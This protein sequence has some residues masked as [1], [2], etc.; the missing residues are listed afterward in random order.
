[1]VTDDE[2]LYNKIVKIR[3]FG[4]RATGVDFHEVVGYNFKFTD[5][6]AVIGIEQMKKLTWRVERKKE[7]FRE[8][9]KNLA[10]V[11]AVQFLPTDL[12]NISPWFIDVLVP[13][14]LALRDHLKKQG[15]GTRMFYPAIHSQPAYN[16]TGNYPATEYAANHGLW[17]PSS[18]FLSD[19]EVR[20][21]S[22][23]IREYYTHSH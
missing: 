22:E 16:A 12:T 13:E 17:L 4:R 23:S 14:P 3:D 5:L 15:V 18:S 1:L 8:Y 7:I 19:D 11:A 2:D 9:Q 6:Q 21:I 20:C 10:D